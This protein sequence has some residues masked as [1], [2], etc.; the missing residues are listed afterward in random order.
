MKLGVNHKTGKIWSITSWKTHTNPEMGIFNLD[1][2]PNG[3][4]LELRRRGVVYWRSGKFTSNSF[5]FILPYQRQRYNFSM[6][7][8]EYEDYLTY[9]ALEDQT[10]EPEWILRFQGRL[11]DNDDQVGIVEADMCGAYNTEGGCQRRDRTPDCTTGFEFSNNFEEKNGSFKPST[12]S[13]SSSR[14]PY[15][16]N[17]ASDK[18]YSSSSTDCQATCWQDCDCIGYDFLFDN[19]TGCRFW[20]VDCPF[21]EDLTGSATTTGFVV[22]TR[23]PMIRTSSSSRKKGKNRTKI[24]QKELLSFMRSNRPTAVDG[25]Q[26]DGK[27]GQDLS[28]FSY[29][30]V[31]AATCNFSEENKLGQEGFGPVYKGKLVTGRRNSCEEAFKIFRARRV[32]VQE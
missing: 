26:I 15:W 12:S 2:D 6:V 8:N 17:F 31:L 4:Q 21:S 20:S 32:R 3:H 22:M 30:S 9:A 5:E 27:M 28:V 11:Y 29:A 24:F 18:N 13:L 1:W 19:Q 14:C 25:L 23:P 10:N 7:S 16:L